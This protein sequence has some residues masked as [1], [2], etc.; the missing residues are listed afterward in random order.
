MIV[1]FQTVSSVLY[2]THAS[3][4][5]LFSYVL[6]FHHRTSINAQKIVDERHGPSKPNKFW[7]ASN[8]S[9][10]FDH[11]YVANSMVKGKDEGAISSFKAARYYNDQ[12]A[13]RRDELLAEIAAEEGS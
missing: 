10:D 6:H 13:K 3:S 12:S 7:A 9:R 8:K 5:P 2:F 11:I 1:R 4:L